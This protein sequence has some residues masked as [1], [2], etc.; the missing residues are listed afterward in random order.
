[1]APETCP[2][3]GADIPRN[4]KVCPECGADENTGWSD[5]A[6]SGG[7]GL[8]DEEFDYDEFVKREFGTEKKPRGVGWFWWI[9][10]VV[11]LFL[12]V[13]LVVR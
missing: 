9:V 5:A 6:R 12:F 4:A 7:L 3:C 11:V 13:L 1:M 2:N 8:P 10:A